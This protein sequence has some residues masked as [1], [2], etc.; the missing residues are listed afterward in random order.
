[1][2]ASDDIYS[3]ANRSKRFKWLGIGVI[4]AIIIIIIVVPI[5]VLVPRAANSKLHQSNVILPL[6]IYPL[7]GAWDPL[8]EV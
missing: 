7:P 1:M 3:R 4:A 5:V 6:Y 2:E 8:Y